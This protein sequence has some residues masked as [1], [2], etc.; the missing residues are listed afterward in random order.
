MLAFE[1]T[2]GASDLTLFTL[3]TLETL[4]RTL[5]DLENVVDAFDVILGERDGAFEEISDFLLDNCETPLLRDATEAI[6]DR[7]E[8]AR[9]WFPRN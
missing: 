9:D 3:E 2:L 1:T 5:E 7:R 4:D 6:L 8:L